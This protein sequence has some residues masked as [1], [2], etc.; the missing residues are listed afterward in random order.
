MVA[1]SLAGC[2]GPS[3]P[4]ASEADRIPGAV[5]APQWR[6]GDWWTY[7]FSTEVYEKTF[8]ATV[9]VGQVTETGYVLGMPKDKYELNAILF[10]LPPLGTVTRTLG[11]NV[12]DVLFEPVRFPLSDGLQWQTTWVT[13]PIAFTAKAATVQT[14]GGSEQGFH[15]DNEGR[16]SVSAGRLVSLEYAPSVG[17]LSKY[18][19]RDPDGR[20]RE[21]IVLKDSGHG[22]SGEVRLMD[23]IHMALLALRS[24]NNPSEGL[25]APSIPFAV[26]GEHNTI[27][28]ACVWGDAPGYYR[29]SVRHPQMTACDATGAVG[30]G[31]DMGRRFAL[32]EVANPGGYW[33]ASLTAAGTGVALVEVMSYHAWD[34]TLA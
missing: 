26:P 11:Y 15:I 14:P 29:A 4:S 20:V 17:W 23:G 32:S 16:E 18:E 25:V 31:A 10:H 8:E 24:A 5:E 19:R 22:A 7:E 33:E 9:V 28:A 30:P 13:A 3:L 27:F 2:L 6:V 12:H 21:R 1:V 34:A